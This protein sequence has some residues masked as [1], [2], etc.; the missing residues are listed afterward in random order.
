MLGTTRSA[1]VIAARLLD[2]PEHPTVCCRVDDA[3][4][5]ERKQNSHPAAK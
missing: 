4:E 3:S 5:L 1:L 2:S